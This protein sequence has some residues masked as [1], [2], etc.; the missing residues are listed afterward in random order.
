MLTMNA[1]NK[2]KK[3]IENNEELETVGDVMKCFIFPPF[4]T[5]NSQST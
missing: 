5:N 1:Y 2:Q 4:I 3:R